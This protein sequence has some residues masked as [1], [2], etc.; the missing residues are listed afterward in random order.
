MCL[1]KVVLVAP[2]AR[3][4]RAGNSPDLPRIKDDHPQ[5]QA[6][7]KGRGRQQLSYASYGYTYLKHTSHPIHPA[8]SVF[9]SAID[10][11]GPSYM[12]TTP[13][14]SAA[15]TLSRPNQSLFP[16]K[17][18]PCV[19]KEL[20]QE[21]IQVLVFDSSRVVSFPSTPKISPEEESRVRAGR[22]GD[23]LSCIVSDIVGTYVVKVSLSDLVVN[24]PPMQVYIKVADLV[25]AIETIDYGDASEGPVSL[26]TSKATDIFDM[27]N[28]AWAVA[29]HLQIESRLDRYKLN[30]RLF[31]KHPEFLESARELIAQGTP[32]RP[33]HASCLSFPASIDTKTASSY[34]NFIAFTCFNVY[35]SQ[36]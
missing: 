11:F 34:C 31:I 24:S 18:I 3:F 26:P 9:L 33:E 17:H 1:E 14:F 6:S 35:E 10:N 25:Q 4:H 13:G 8:F 29:N 28:V 19:S 5:V 23:A 27:P 2:I 32:L 20:H 21:V 16:K 36:G 7:A 15:A 22:V 12:G 30:P